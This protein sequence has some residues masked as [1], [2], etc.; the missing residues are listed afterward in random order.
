MVTLISV[1]EAAELC[2]Y[3]NIHIRVLM[4]KGKFPAAIYIRIGH[5]RS[6]LHFQK[7]EIEA[8]VAD[9]EAKKTAKRMVQS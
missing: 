5:T 7:A 4:R 9:R 3:H 1:K 8:W 6:R 2:G